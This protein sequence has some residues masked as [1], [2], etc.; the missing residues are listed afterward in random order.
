VTAAFSGD[1]I[2]GEAET[3]GEAVAVSLA[4]VEGVGAIDI[5]VGV[6]VGHGWNGSGD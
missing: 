6:A 4:V 1:G 3:T 5:R 2:A